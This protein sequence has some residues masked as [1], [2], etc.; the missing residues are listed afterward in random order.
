MET[1]YSRP[2]LFVDNVERSIAF[3]TEKLGFTEGDRYEEDG[4]VLVGQV[5]REDCALLLTCQEPDKNG[6]GRMFIS[7]DLEPFLAYRAELEK[8]GAPIRMGWWGYDTMIVEDPDGN[9]M[10]FP[11]PDDADPATDGDD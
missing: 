10:F 9:E 8:R 11:Y 2:V 7:L 6:R 3:Y 5:S 1:W 4:K